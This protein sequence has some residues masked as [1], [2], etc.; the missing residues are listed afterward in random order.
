MEGEQST[1][2]CLMWGWTKKNQIAESLKNV[3]A[4]LKHQT[5][6]TTLNLNT[7]YFKLTFLLEFNDLKHFHINSLIY[8]IRDSLV[9]DVSTYFKR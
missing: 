2:R 5:W 7:D 1:T 9:W 3:K 6:Q 4:P 8:H